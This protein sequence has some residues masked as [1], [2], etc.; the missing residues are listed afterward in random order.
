VKEIRLAGQSRQ[1]L[2]TAE[3]AEGAEPDVLL[4]GVL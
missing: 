1:E 2:F 3:R 4:L